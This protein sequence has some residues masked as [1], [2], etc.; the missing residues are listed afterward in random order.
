MAEKR[1]LDGQIMKKSNLPEY[2]QTKHR[3]F[4]EISDEDRLQFEEKAK[5]HN[6]ALREK[7]DTS[8]IFE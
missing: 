2:H 3:L 8:H 6:I 4:K 5:A 1:D 7:P